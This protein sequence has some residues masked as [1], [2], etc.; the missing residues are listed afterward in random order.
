MQKEAF[1]I[2]QLVYFGLKGQDPKTKSLCRI[3][4]KA[5]ERKA[6]DTSPLLYSE[7]F[8]GCWELQIICEKHFR[9]ETVIYPLYTFGSPRAHYFC[10]GHKHYLSGIH[11]YL[12]PKRKLTFYTDENYMSSLQEK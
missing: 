7:Y 12:D 11:I 9:I 3:T 8:A 10:G 4:G 1:K 5:Q 2:G 6:G